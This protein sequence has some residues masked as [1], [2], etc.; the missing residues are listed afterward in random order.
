MDLLGG[1]SRL[2]QQLKLV[3]LPATLFKNWLMESGNIVKTVK[4]ENGR[5]SAMLS[6]G[7][8]IGP[9]TRVTGVD[10]YAALEKGLSA[11]RQWQPDQRTP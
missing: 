2:L 7:T 5:T 8:S 6:P 11:S 9:G 1:W 4:I 10:I 3:S